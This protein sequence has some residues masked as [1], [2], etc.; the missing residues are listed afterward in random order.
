ME[1]TQA[2]FQSRALQH[3]ARRKPGS[4]LKTRARQYVRRFMPVG[5]GRLAIVAGPLTI[6]FHPDRPTRD[7]LSAIES[8]RLSGRIQSQFESGTSNGFGLEE[9]GAVRVLREASLF[10]G[11]Y[12]HAPAHQRPKYGAINLFDN[13]RGGWPRFGSSYWTLDPCIADRC[14]VT[15][16]GSHSSRAWSGRCTELAEL[17]PVAQDGSA[18]AS[19]RRRFQLIDGPVELQ[20]HGEIML[21]RDVIGV[22]LD[23]SFRKTAIE[24]SAVRVA[25][26]FGIAM[27][28]TPELVSSGV[29]WNL[30]SARQHARERILG[31]VSTGE[32]ITAAWIGE[33]LWTAPAGTS[34]RATAGRASRYLWNRLLLSQVDIRA[35]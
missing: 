8:I 5:S 12:D 34:E 29:D 11:A 27:S 24:E 10:G 25:A 26:A 19:V 3:V 31:A 18:A 13:P 14:T 15:I 23:P 6:N 20:I 22:V 32:A 1:V 28:W 33:G 9:K 21:G 17:L 2:A 7:G 4:E 30:G 16:P 35:T